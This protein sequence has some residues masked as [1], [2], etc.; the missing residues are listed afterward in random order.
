MTTTRHLM[1][2]LTVFHLDN[3]EATWEDLKA[4]LAEIAEGALATPGEDAYGLVLSD[5]A[6]SLQEAARVLPLSIPQAKAI[7]LAYRVLS[8]SQARLSGDLKPLLGLLDN[9]LAD[10]IDHAYQ[11]G[12]V[13]RDNRLS[14]SQSVGPRSVPAESTTTAPADPAL[15]F[16]FQGLSDAFEAERSES[17]APATLKN[18]RS[19]TKTIAGI[20]GAQD[21]RSHTRADMLG[22]RERLCETRKG[23]TVNK[24]LTHLSMVIAWAQATGLITHDYSKKLTIT[25]GAESSR[26]AFSTDQIAT[27]KAASVGHLASD[28]KGAAMALGVA[29]G[30]RIGEIHQ[31]LGEDIT[32]DPDTGLWL[33]SINDNNGK[34]L[35][36]KFS[37]RV[38]P[39]V[40]VPDS[41]CEALAGTVGPLFTMSMS[42]FAQMLNQAVR[43]VLGTVAGEGL[44]FHSLRHSLATD[45]KTSG[46]PLGTAQ[47][48]LGHSSGSISYD[49]YGG[50]AS[51][52]VARLA[53]AL[54]KVR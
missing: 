17:M 9:E 50:S 12:A 36:N 47:E 49:L 45:L 26:Q 22:V 27:L 28:W 30:A 38:V 51:T 32:K 2:A 19:S 44:S 7:T 48:I 6:E 34:T 43:D 13:D 52:D 31:L 39:L 16:T 1:S 24:L 4:R 29:T 21:M 37:R 10:S 15:G 46:C 41:V 25:K 53:T 23:S 11:L 8:A 35:K 3:P 33:M 18:F 5:L 20:L 40:G 42:G 14:L 54:A